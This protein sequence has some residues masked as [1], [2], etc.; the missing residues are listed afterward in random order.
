[1]NIS[2]SGQLDQNS[3]FVSLVQEI[4]KNNNEL[5]KNNNEM[6]MKSNNKIVKEI[7]KGMKGIEGL[8]SEALD[9]D[10]YDKLSE[11]SHTRKFTQADFA[12]NFKAK[13]SH[14]RCMVSGKSNKLILVHLLPRSASNKFK[15]TLAIGVSEIDCVRNFLILCEGFERAFDAKH[16][17]FIPAENPFSD[18]KY[19]LK[20][21]TE[22][23]KN[24]QI[25]EGS[26]ETIGDYEDAPLVLKVGGLD[27]NPFRRIISYQAFR[28]F[29]TWY[30]ILRL[31]H[32]PVNCDVSEYQGSYRLSRKSFEDQL[33]RD[34]AQDLQ[35]DDDKDEGGADVE[36]DE[37]NDE[38]DENFDAEV[39][40]AAYGKESGGVGS[41]VEGAHE[42]CG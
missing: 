21:W 17:S 25:Y 38:I 12:S 15:E 14:L 24:L 9:S 19:V 18:N 16:I 13:Q 23:V 33:A 42:K 8:V 35:Y 31:K 22:S 30:Q 41:E 4:V 37:A 11:N 29:K 40:A 20:I 27:H 1:M 39:M 28:A 6:M 5:V 3:Q 2:Y 7:V 34:F 10:P 36:F 32:L 26:T